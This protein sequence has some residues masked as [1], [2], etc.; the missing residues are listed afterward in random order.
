MNIRF[1]SLVMFCTARPTADT[2]TSTIKVHLLGVIPAPRDAG[3]DIGLV[4]MIAD[5]HGDRLAQYLAAEI[6][7]RHFARRSPIPGRWGWKPVRSC[8]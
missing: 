5:D 3:A 7:Y 4:L 6:V 8:R 1:F 2:G